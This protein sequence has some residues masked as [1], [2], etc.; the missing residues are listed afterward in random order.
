MNYQERSITK[1][2][3]VILPDIAS[4]TI[5]LLTCLNTVIVLYSL[6]LDLVG[7]RKT[8]RRIDDNAQNC[9]YTTLHRG[10]KSMRKKKGILLITHDG[11]Y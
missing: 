3:V 6:L 11:L 7:N 10:V 5:G 1:I 8:P 4:P 9:V 2:D